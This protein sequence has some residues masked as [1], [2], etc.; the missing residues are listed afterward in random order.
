MRDFLCKKSRK[1]CD[2]PLDIHSSICYNN[3]V[4]R[5]VQNKSPR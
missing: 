4:R 2:L 5:A 1:K 3:S